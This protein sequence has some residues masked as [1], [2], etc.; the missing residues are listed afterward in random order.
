MR[1]KKYKYSIK[2]TLMQLIASIKS[3]SS[4]NFLGMKGMEIFNKTGQIPL[5]RRRILFQCHYH[6]FEQI[7][8]VTVYCSKG[9]PANI[10]LFKINNGNTRTICEI[11]STLTMKTPEQRHRESKQAKCISKLELTRFSTGCSDDLHFKNV[12]FKKN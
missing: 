3:E 2:L 12:K 8:T 10:F 5:Q 9:F 1:T 11:C 6:Y 7:F 4:V